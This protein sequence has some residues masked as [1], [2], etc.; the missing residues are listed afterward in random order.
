MGKYKHA[1]VVI[2]LTAL[3]T[4]GL[5]AF[6]RFF[7]FRLPTAASEEA[8]PIDAM[9]NIHFWLQA[10]LFS[11]IMVITL[12][13][14][15]AFRRQPGD[16]EDAPH[17]HGHTGLEIIWTIVPTIVVIIFG[18]YGY[19]VLTD[20][21]AVE[22]N[23]RAVEVIGRQWSWK[24]E[25]PDIGGQSSSELVLLVNQPVVLQMYSEDVIHSFWVPEF[26]VKQDLL[27]VANPGE[28]Y[29]E[30]RIT[31]TKEGAYKTRCAEI[32]GLE[33]SQM[34]ADVLVLNQADYDAWAAEIS[35]KPGLDDLEGLTPAERGEFWY[36]EFGCNG[37]HKLDGTDGAGPTWL[38]IY[39][40]EEELAD[41]STVIVDH[42]YLYESILDPDAKVTAGFNPG[43]MSTQNFEDR[44]NSFGFSDADQITNDL[45]AFIETL[46]E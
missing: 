7:L 45:I 1:L 13:S 28:D 29:F 20:L 9:F 34:V 41:G 44:F 12:Y 26:R 36:T 43:I 15:Y 42:D 24:F 4:V 14:V 31:P 35:G 32:C 27:P 39:N 25:Y 22:P 23:E 8:G 10:F 30:L 16:E 3:A 19:T 17:I 46:N 40:S 37:C 6:F 11:M 5:F 21:L 33:H 38:G 18:Y 2:I